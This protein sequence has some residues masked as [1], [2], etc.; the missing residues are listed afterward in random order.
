MRL[1]LMVIAALLASPALSQEAPRNCQDRTSILAEL[2]SK[3]RESPVAMGLDSTGGL[4]EVLATEG[5]RTWTIIISRPDGFAC[6]L[7]S[8]EAWRQRS[9][10]PSGPAA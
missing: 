7:S 4:I 1:I 9:P 8:G 3:Y 6:V 10:A 2:A 5:G